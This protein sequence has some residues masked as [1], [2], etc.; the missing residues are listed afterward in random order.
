MTYLDDGVAPDAHAH[1]GVFSARFELP[2]GETPEMAE[3]YLVQVH[4]T[5]DDG[6]FR[7]VAGG[8]LYTAPWARLTGNFRDR[9]ED[10]DLVVSAGSRS[11]APAASTWRAR[12]TP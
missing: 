5:L 9:M 4:A 11:N 8:F 3:A 2:E 7:A 6:D 1:D 12:S 10:G